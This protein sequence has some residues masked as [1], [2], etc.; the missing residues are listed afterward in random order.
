MKNYI[1]CICIYLLSTSS[2]LAGELRLSPEECQNWGKTA[3]ITQKAQQEAVPKEKLLE[4]YLNEVKESPREQ[5]EVDAI[6][7]M[8]NEVY[9]EYDISVPFMYVFQLYYST[10]MEKR[11]VVYIN[12]DI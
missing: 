3:A 9:R 10:C 12:T 8:I 6:V 4:V 5:I 2:V 11:G 1:L 7:D